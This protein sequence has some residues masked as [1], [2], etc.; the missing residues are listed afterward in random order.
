[1]NTLVDI[2]IFIL[3]TLGGFYLLFVILR[4]LLQT[5]RADFYNPFSQAVVKITNPVLIPLR[6]I[7]P[8]LAGIDLASLVLALLTQLLFGEIVAF[9]FMQKFFNPGQILVWGI[10]GTLMYTSYVYIGCLLVMVVSSFIAPYS[11]HPIVMLAK[12][13]TEPLVRPVQK[14]IPPVGGFDFSVMFVFMGVYI[15][16]ILIRSFA[17]STGLLPALV[18]GF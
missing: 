14:I 8:G 2:L 3:E 6:K 18:I 13:I 12:Q 1:M 7:I 9:I 15:V 16:Q 17:Q 5:V 10:F 11:T 4:F